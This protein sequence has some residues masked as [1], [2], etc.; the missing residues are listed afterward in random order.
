M[1]RMHCSL[2]VLSAVF[3]L[4]AGS[5]IRAHGQAL[6]TVGGTA[7]APF[8]LGF[9]PRGTAMG[10]ALAAVIDGDLVGYYNPA[11]LPFQ[12]T[13]WGM[14]AY[15]F[16]SLDRHLNALSY[17]QPLRPNAGLGLSLI[18]AGVSEIEERDRDG[19]L[20]GTTSTS[21]N[22]FA[23]S[24]GLRPAE[25][26]AFG[27]TAKIFHYS[28][29]DQA[30]ST[31]VGFDAGI[32]VRVSER[33]TLAGAL[34]DLNSRYRWETTSLYGQNGSSTTDRFPL[35]KQVG[36]AWHDEQIGLTAAGTFERV[37]GASF[38]K[39]GAEY[40]YRGRFGIRAG[41]DQVSTDKAVTARP[42][43]GASFL[44][45]IGSWPVGFQ[46]SYQFEPYSPRG[47]HFLSLSVLIE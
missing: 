34:L 9:G 25:E 28:L 2:G 18:N 21:E 24:F 27:V 8:R 12:R 15:S 19:R 33:W 39:A 10:N 41:I 5:G 40:M 47:A 6:S 1:I 30:T 31:T 14:A 16:L 45:T 32:L 20:T 23:F 38:V 4:L 36:I 44:A 3:L 35:R 42:A 22:A 7:G 26:F 11:V 43:L 29:Y 46:Y 37:A 17:V 13:A